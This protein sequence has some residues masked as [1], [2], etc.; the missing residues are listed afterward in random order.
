MIL[1]AG[2]V[3]ATSDR[4]SSCRRLRELLRPG[5]FM[6]LSEVTHVVDWYDICFGL[7]EGWWLSGGDK[8]YPIPTAEA[9]MDALERA[10]FSSMGTSPGS[11]EEFRSQKLL[12]ASNKE[13]TVPSLG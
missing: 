12:V 13:W 3:H 11:T 7:L 1:G 10:G 6:V 9:W 5:E 4:N 8:E 2:V